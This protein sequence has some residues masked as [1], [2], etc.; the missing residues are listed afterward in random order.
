MKLTKRVAKLGRGV[1]WMALP[2]LLTAG[3]VGAQTTPVANPDIESIRSE[4]RQMQQ[5]Y[6]RRM[7][8]LEKRLEQI[9]S[10]AATNLPPATNISAMPAP[11]KV[12][13]NAMPTESERGNAFANI[14]Y[15]QHGA[16][17]ESVLAQPENA[18]LKKRIDQVLND[19]VDTGGYFRAGY[20][21]DD[22]G[23]PQPAFMA[24]GAF[25]K[26]RLGN[27]AEDY[28][29]FMVGKNWYVPDL[30]STDAG[31]RPDGT[32]TGPIARTQVRMAFYDPYS[33]SGGNSTDVTSAGGVGEHR[34]RRGLAAIAEILGR[35]SFLSP[36][37][38]PHQ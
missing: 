30:F 31:E 8:L 10:G 27:E 26:Y 15:D 34:Q 35:Q 32:P 9:E 25:A 38:H 36:A 16:A 37:G 13:T 23:G 17:H 5:D 14:Q 28:G 21:R 24:P 2:G 18:V 33:S 7:D 19:F 12:A 3:P 29:E 20:G 6:E 4:M 22:K 1:L 11:V